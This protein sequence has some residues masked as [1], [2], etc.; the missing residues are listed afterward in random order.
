MLTRRLV[1]APITAVAARFSG[2][3]STDP[4][5]E[6]DRWLEA[7]LH[8]REKTPE[9]R[10][11]AEKQREILSKLMTKVRADTHKVV[12]EVKEQHKTEVDSLKEQMATLQ[13]KLDKLQK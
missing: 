10:Y 6:D 3:K 9:E 5:Y 7:Q 2:V 8:D 13:K 4:T 1:A 11:A 12:Q